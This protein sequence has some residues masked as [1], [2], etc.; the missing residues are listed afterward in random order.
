MTSTLDA[1]V[2]TPAVLD[3]DR[4]GPGFGVN[5]R[6]VDL[7]TADD[8]TIAAVRRGDGAPDAGVARGVSDRA[9]RT[10]GGT[11]RRGDAPREGT[12]RP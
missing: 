8:A 2:T 7:A 3:L 10:A 9:P 4:L 1:P 5:V 11:G 6:G 12:R